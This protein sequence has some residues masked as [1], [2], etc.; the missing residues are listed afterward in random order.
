[1]KFST[2][3]LSYAGI[4]LTS[5]V[6]LHQNDS[7]MKEKMMY[8]SDPQLDKKVDSPSE[9]V[10]MKIAR[11]GYGLD[12]LVHDPSEQVRIEVAIHKFGLD[13]LKDDPD[14][15]VRFI[16]EHVQK[17]KPK[18]ILDDTHLAIDVKYGFDKEMDALADS[19][20]VADRVRIA[21]A[22]YALDLLV[23]DPSPMVRCE[24]LKHCYGIHILKNDPSPRVRAC[25]RKYIKSTIL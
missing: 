7:I 9:K 21:R 17:P 2:I 19:P 3:K 5:M 4:L 6:S 23:Y 22:G 18:I 13:I 16:V 8:G 11:Q 25:Y 1:M 20:R 10:R 24:V 15:H 14:E 12:K